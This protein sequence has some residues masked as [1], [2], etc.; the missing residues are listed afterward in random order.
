MLLIPVLVKMSDIV[1]SVGCGSGVIDL[2]RGKPA[3]CL[4]AADE[5]LELVPE[6]EPDVSALPC[7]GL[8]G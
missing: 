4:L 7:G 6:V 1:V 3:S 5:A 8:F 2:V